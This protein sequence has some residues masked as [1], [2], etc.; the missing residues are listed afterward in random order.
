MG[1]PG[2]QAAEPP[3]QPARLGAVTA[4]ACLQE[5][6]LHLLI[7]PV[8]PAEFS[9]GVFRYENCLDELVQPV[10]VNIGQYWG[11]DAALRGNTT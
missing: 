2:G 4:L 3:P 10:Q 1:I 5:R 7:L 8:V 11:C 6:I 9:S